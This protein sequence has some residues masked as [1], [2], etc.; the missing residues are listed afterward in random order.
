VFR[1]PRGGAATFHVTFHVPPLDAPAAGVFVM[2]TARTG[3]EVYRQEEPFRILTPASRPNPPLQ[4]GEPA[5]FDPANALGDFPRA[6]RIP[7]ATVKSPEE[8]PASAR[9][10]IVGP[11]AIAPDRATDPIW[12]WLAAGGRK[13]LVLDPAHPLAYRTLP[14]DYEPTP[15][16]GRIAFMEDPSHPVFDGLAQADFFTWGNDHVVYRN[17]YRKGTG[18]GR[19]LPRTAQGLLVS[20]G[21]SGVRGE[22]PGVKCGGRRGRAEAGGRRAGRQGQ[23]GKRRA[24]QTV[25]L[26]ARRKCSKPRVSAPPQRRGGSFSWRRAW[27]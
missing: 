11:E 1:L 19:L 21:C 6:R 7:F 25:P 16:T 15:H 10:I 22:G 27:A 2:R 26:R 8:I 3:H 5:I 12:F 13:V 14:D 4:P 17:A 23:T 20:R 9:V 18:G 24:G